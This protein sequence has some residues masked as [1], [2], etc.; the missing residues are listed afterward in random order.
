MKIKKNIIAAVMAMGVAAS[1]SGGT[2]AQY[3]SA[4]VLTVSAA[5]SV[6][7]FEGS[8]TVPVSLYNY[9]ES[10][11]S[12][13]NPAMK[14]VGELV[15]DKNG[16]ASVILEFQRM[17]YGDGE[18][19]LGHF[20]K[21]KEITQTGFMGVPVKADVEEAAVVDEYT[22]IYHT[23]NDPTSKNADSNVA[24]KWY[25]QKVSVPVDVT[26][27]ESGNIT[28]VDGYLA[29][30]YTGRESNYNNLCKQVLC[31]VYVPIMESIG[32]TS[33]GGTKFVGL[34][35]DWDN[36]QKKE[37]ELTG[38]SAS[39]K[40]DIT[41]NNYIDLSSNVTSDSGAKIV[42]KIDGK[43][44]SEVKVKD[45]T[46]TANGYEIPVEVAAKDMTSEI[47]VEVQLGNGTVVDTYSVSAVDYAMEIAYGEG[48][49]DKQKALAKAMLNYGG[50]AQ[51]FF[52]VNT[53]KLANANLADSD[54]SLS[55]VTASTL[56]GY[57]FSKSGSVSG[58]SYKGSSLSLASKTEIKHYFSLTGTNDIS[59][60]KFTVNGTNVTPT[61]SSQGYYVTVPKINA[62]NLGDRYTVT[63]SN[64]T[65][66]FTLKYGA[67]D[68][69][70]IAQTKSSNEALH[71]V[72]K[73]LYLFYK[74]A[75]A[76]K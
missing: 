18:G 22:G 28:G 62:A 59:K 11:A 16:N 32:T 40:G 58:I 39:I 69:C 27:D 23:F 66:T 6:A 65:N 12:M 76:N 36:V 29:R 51:E 17:T 38:T 44:V 60:Y 71:N 4:P 74:A 3:F 50:Y 1:I 64:G 70:N 45:Q 8:Y 48:Y 73:A 61:M 46:A 7:D 21:C 15:I 13:G 57:N 31:Q 9:T 42:S 35:I 41:L 10:K 47:T 43:T 53:D 72:S 55:S 20:Y 54:K 26:V 75:E 14:Q 37:S 24:G 33:G 63:V 25:P 49:T 67:M 5:S 2:A 19:Y 30:F 56:S 52:G 68:Y 34:L